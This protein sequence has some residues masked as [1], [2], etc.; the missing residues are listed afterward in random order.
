MFDIAYCRL[1]LCTSA[2]T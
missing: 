2:C 1:L